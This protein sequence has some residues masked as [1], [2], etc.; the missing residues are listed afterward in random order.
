MKVLI[1]GYSGFLGNFLSKNLSK[2]FEIIKLNL[3]DIPV[4][5]S[6]SF[7]LFLDQFLEADFIINCAACLKPKSESDIFINQEFPGILAEYLHRKK[8]NILFIHISTLNVLIENRQDIYTTTK[9][10]AENKLKNYNVIIIRLPLIFEKIKNII[11][12]TGNFKKIDA[13]LNLSFLP[14]YPMVFPGHIHK[15]VEIVKIYYFIEKILLNKKRE[16][17]TYNIQG[18]DEKNL[19]DLFFEM[20]TKR[21]KKTLRI[22]LILFNRLIPNIVKNYLKK[23]SSFLQQLIIIDHSIFDE[24]IEY[25]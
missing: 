3:R 7:D 10:N 6:G 11:Q 19:W 15:P 21:K 4:K 22:N 14:I 20:A 25:L 5:E 9:R 23:N 12:G 2:N 13:Y 17:L 24:K 1:T 18:R 8:K 16:Y